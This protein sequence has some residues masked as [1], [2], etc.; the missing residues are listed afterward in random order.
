MKFTGQGFFTNPFNNVDY[1]G[2]LILY[3]GQTGYSEKNP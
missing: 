2:P 3:R 1:C